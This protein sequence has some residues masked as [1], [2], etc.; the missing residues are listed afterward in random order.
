MSAYKEFKEVW[1]HLPSISPHPKEASGYTTGRVLSAMRIDADEIGLLKEKLNEA[2]A[3][4]SAV[5]DQAVEA[6]AEKIETLRDN[7]QQLKL[8][9][10]EM[11]AQEQRTLKAGMGLFAFLLRSLKRSQSQTGTDL[12]C[13]ASPGIK[14]ETVSAAPLQ[15]SILRMGEEGQLTGAKDRLGREIRIGDILRF[16][17][18][19]WNRSARSGAQED[20]IFIMEYE[21]GQLVH[22]GSY[23]DLSAWCEVI[24]P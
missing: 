11:E 4:A 13:Q 10:G 7:T 5:W 3:A 21:D 19:E 6:C 14:G 24:K 2:E 9:M 22:P 16:D 20:C 12:L 1:G 23:S 18:D 15:S 8:H 17:Y